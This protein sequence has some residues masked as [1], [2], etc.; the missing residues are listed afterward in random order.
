MKRITPYECERRWKI[1]LG[2]EHQTPSGPALSNDGNGKPKQPGANLQ[3]S[4][5]EGNRDG[6]GREDDPYS[7]D[8]IITPSSIQKVEQV[9]EDTL[10]KW[11]ALNDRKL[12]TQPKSSSTAAAKSV[13]FQFPNGNESDAEL[14]DDNDDSSSRKPS[15][16]AK[17]PRRGNG[18]LSANGVGWGW[19]YSDKYSLNLPEDF[20]YATKLPE[21]P[22]DDG[23]GDRVLDLM[24]PSRTLSYEQELWKVFAS[25][26]SIQDLD[27]E[28]FEG[29]QLPHSH[30]M[31]Q[32]IVEGL[33]EHARMD[34][35]H[36]S[37][38]RANQRHGMPS[39]LAFGKRQRK[40]DEGHE[41]SITTVRIE[42]LR[43]QVGRGASVS[44]HRAV[45]EFMASQTLLDV[46]L[47]LVAMID[48]KLWDRQFDSHN[49]TSSQNGQNDMTDE[50][51]K[52][53][54][55]LVQHSGIF[56]VEDTFYVTGAVDYIQPIQQWI[57]GGETPNTSRRECLGINTQE[58]LS[59][60]SMQEMKL[61][62]LAT[63]FNFRYYHCMHGDVETAMF[64]TDV[65]FGK[66]ATIPYPIIHD[67][68]GQTY[69]VSDCD[70]CHLFHA[71]Y[72]TS[73]KCAI[74]DGSRSLCVQCCQKL[75]LLERDPQN[76]ELYS[77]WKSQS[78]LSRGATDSAAF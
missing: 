55:Q 39:V 26:P 23:S 51:S 17:K 47:A 30:T 12:N 72:V 58:P 34:G 75:K 71:T 49:Q 4:D 48:D 70:A 29:M 21:P 20:D 13:T 33:L 57:D 54:G 9:M 14:E 63:R 8:D 42:F 52:S 59:V 38:L 5:R 56:F 18:L 28:R 22:P 7:C 24:D 73:S 37:R 61:G 35:H 44:P 62:H 10:Q 68:F 31:Y 19:K 74:T 6:P 15:A 1:L 3:T 66:A 77:V 46:H 67:T 64:F 43:Q 60:K 16:A 50:S 27:R 65:Q 25:V 41:N 76:V 2:L 45:M 40:Q 53:R 78:D 36:L 11:N 32:E 69:P